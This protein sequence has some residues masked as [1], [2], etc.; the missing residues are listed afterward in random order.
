MQNEIN[1]RFILSVYEKIVTKGEAVEGELEGTH[2]LEGVTAF[3]DF[4]GYTVYLEDAEVKVRT[5]FH[6]TFKVDYD[7]ARALDNFVRKMKHIEAN[8]G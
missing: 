5:G 4:D 3:A 7:T 1:T 2:Q 6:N 8:Y